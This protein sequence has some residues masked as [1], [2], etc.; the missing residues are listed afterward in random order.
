MPLRGHLHLTCEPD[1]AGK[2]ILRHQSF[3]TPIHL[4]KP[5]WDGDTLLVNVVNPTAGLLSGDTIEC[6]V[7]VKPGAK[8]LLTSPSAS[9]SFTMPTGEARLRQKFAVAA[10]A[11]LEVWPE[12]FIPQRGTRYRQT[13]EVRLEH[14]AEFMLFETLAPGRVASGEAFEYGKLFWETD[15]LLAD[16]LVARERYTISPDSPTVLA[17]RKQFPTAYYASCFAVAPGLQADSPCWATIDALHDEGTVWVGF[18][19]LTVGGQ[20]TATENLNSRAS[21]AW[22]IKVIAA[23]S[24]ALR[25]TL[26]AIREALYTS[27]GE[28]PTALRRT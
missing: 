3:S 14:G 2:S 4:S 5:Y 26:T 15:V 17:M 9:R 22:S 13:T 27:Q 28:T 7:R 23:D 19:A 11:R 20:T 6:D 16:R 21:N 12:F 1:S 18:S 10:G 25:K 24:V 8:L